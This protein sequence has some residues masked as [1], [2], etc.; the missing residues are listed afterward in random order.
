MEGKDQISKLPEQILDH[1]LSFL[2]IKDAEKT[3]ALS[4]FT[5]R[6]AADDE[7]EKPCTS[8]PWKCW[9]HELKRVKLQNFTR[10]ELEKLR[11]FFFENIDTLSITEDPSECSLF[12]S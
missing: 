11:N 8:L 6:N 4:K 5:Y 10:T 7:D 9:R 1:I 12:T 3:S 2:V